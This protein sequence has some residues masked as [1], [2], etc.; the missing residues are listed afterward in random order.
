[1]HNTS[2]YD[3]VRHHGMW[4]TI[5]EWLTPVRM[6]LTN[7]GSSGYGGTTMSELELIRVPRFLLLSVMHL[8]WARI[9]AAGANPSA[10]L[11]GGEVQWIWDFSSALYHWILIQSA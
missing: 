5:V 6:I 4:R 11:T 7:R 3:V 2:Y 10:R 9:T 1:M 8:R